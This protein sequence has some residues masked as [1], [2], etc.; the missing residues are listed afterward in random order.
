MGEVRIE[1]TRYIVTCWPEDLQD[2]PNAATWS[3]TVSLRRDGLWG[4]FMGQGEGLS[5]RLDIDG[6]W[7]FADREAPDFGERYLFPLG[8]ALDLAREAA[9]KITIM[10]KTTLEIIELARQG[11]I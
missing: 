5:R 8:L 4:V 3:I 1:P 2:N 6:E 11:K 10:G 7:G 9:P